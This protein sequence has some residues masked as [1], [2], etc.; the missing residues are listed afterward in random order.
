MLI[1]A[2]VLMLAALAHGEG[3]RFPADAGTWAAVAYLAVAGSVL[4]FLVYFSLMKTWSVLSLSFIS[5]FT[6]VIALLL[7]FAFLGEP[8]TAAKVGGAVLILVA[9]VLA[10]RAA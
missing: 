6:P 1:G 3:F 10:N 7:G 5:V 8:L 9:V 4:A 2:V